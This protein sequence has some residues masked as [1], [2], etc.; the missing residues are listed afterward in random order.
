MAED[1]HRWFQAGL[2]SPATNAAAMSENDSTDLAYTTRAIYVGGAGNVVVDMASGQTSVTFSSVPAGTI[3]PIRVT[4]L[5][6][7]TT[8]TNLVAL[9]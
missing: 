2:E 1:M 7:A 9:Y 6:T 4:R 8:A 3:L 5:R